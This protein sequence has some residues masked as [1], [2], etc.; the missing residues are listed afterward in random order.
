[1]D[2]L[3]AARLQMTV[4][5]V[6]HIVFACI[7]M[8][9]PWLMFVAEWKWIKTGKQVYLDLAKAW[10]R[11]V[12]IFFAVGAVSGTVLSFEL[13]LLW[14]GFMKHAGAIIGMPFSWEGTAFFMEAI[15]LGVFLYGRGRVNNTVHLLSGLVVG[16]A[17][18]I[19]GIFVVAANA[20][21]NSP[22]GFDWVSGQ[23]INIDP[24]TA[25]FNRA[26]FH[27]ALH[28]TFAAFASTCFAV[29]GIHAYM[30]LRN[31][32]NDFHR[33]AIRIAMAFGA[34]SAIIQPLTGDIAAKRVAELQ[35]VKLAAMESLFKTSQPASLIIGGIPDEEMETVKY[36]IHIPGALSFLA[37]GDFNAE[38]QG[39]DKVDRENRPPVA[40]VHFAFQIM[41][42]MGILMMLAG[43]MYLIFSFKWKE[44]LE[45]RWWLKMLFWLTPVGF[46]AVDAGWIVTE[47]GRQP[48]IIYE[49]MKTKDAVSPMPGLQ[50]S[51][52]TVTLIYLALTFIVFWLMRR[53]I[54]VI[55]E[56]PQILND[57]D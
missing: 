42:L 41:V 46:I 13:G 35:P 33:K 44:N 32:A 27:E 20:W 50:F 28:M 11:G 34:V 19:S 53:Q 57:H 21:M 36:G 16:I 24:F 39:L 10:T 43:I 40:I 14:P 4:S 38:V 23:A 37:H 48:W 12:A 45:K 8:T 54:M 26:W 51:L 31:K 52:Y 49:I 22:A 56:N 17:G 18:V 25:M 6:F 9:M 30:L 55:N 47:V 7:G 15:A 5:F 2:A 3:L 29:A 1:M